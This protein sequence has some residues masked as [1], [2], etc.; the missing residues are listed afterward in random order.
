MERNL[1]RLLAD[2]VS[3]DSVNPDLVPG[4]RGEGE[5]AAFVAQWLRRAGLE[6]SLEETRLE[7]RP[8]VMAIARG[9]GGGRT[10]ML[11]AHMDTV[12]VAGMRDPFTPVFR[13][14]RLYGRGALDTK[15]ALAAFMAAAAAADRR[16][17]RGT[18]MLAA[19]AD[20]EY[21][22][23]GTEA[24]AARW[25][26]DAAI[27]G[28]PTGLRVVTAHKGFAW[29][30]IETRGVAAHGSR[31]DVGVDAIAKMGKVLAAIGE[32]AE[33]LAAS[34]PHPLLG[35]GSVHASLIQGGQEFSSYPE[36]CLLRIERRTVPGETR[37][38]VEAELRGLVQRSGRG[39]GAFSATLRHV[40]GREPLEVSGAEPI[41]RA[42]Q[43]AVQRETGVE[44]SPAGMG[45]WMDSSLLAAAGI[46]PVVF[47]PTGEGLHGIS[48]WVELSSV[49][50]CSRIVGKII[51]EICG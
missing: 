35:P 40:F 25:K 31:P 14:G 4:A 43:R 17:L 6:V 1:E 29:F 28:E 38:S 12:G 22:S 11:N 26:A 41:V 20:E 48:E 36:S 13:D 34:K 7:G 30:D 18:V 27:V 3:I 23:A 19:V 44:P 42:L 33:R 46:P 50:A 37:E 47:G 49:Q 32:L 9:S 51:E 45:A 16:T 10:L 39:D 24:V 5:I 15:A 8:N 2:L 21:A